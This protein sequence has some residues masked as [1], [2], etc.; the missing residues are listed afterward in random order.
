M[1]GCWID[2]TWVA[3][4]G[5][6]EMRRESCRKW[7]SLLPNHVEHVS[8][9]VDTDKTGKC[10]PTWNTVQDGGGPVCVC[11]CSDWLDL[12]WGRVVIT[13]MRTVRC[14][15]LRQ[16]VCVQTSSKSRGALP[17]VRRNVLKSFMWENTL[18]QKHTSVSAGQNVPLLHT[19]T[20]YRMSSPLCPHVLV[21][22]CHCP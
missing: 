11:V 15:V 13:H 4:R 2:L 16:D 18:V 5:R 14:H 1:R 7:Q 8:V 12:L 21:V 3:A 9:R 6:E 19:N 10:T 17:P 22:T 20:V